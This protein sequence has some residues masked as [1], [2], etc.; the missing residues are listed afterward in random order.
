M[1]WK[2]VDL[3]AVEISGGTVGDKMLV[4]SIYL[5]PTRKEEHRERL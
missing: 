5:C 3:V 4:V 2:N 1:I